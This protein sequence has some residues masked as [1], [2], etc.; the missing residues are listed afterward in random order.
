MYYISIPVSIIR[1]LKWQ[2]RQKVIV[3]KYG[4]NKILISDWKK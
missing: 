2:E 1:S 3:K 4:H